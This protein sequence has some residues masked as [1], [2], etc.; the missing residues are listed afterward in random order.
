M[1]QFENQSE[2]GQPEHDGPDHVASGSDEWLIQRARARGE[3][4][5]R[6]VPAITGLDIRQRNV[7]DHHRG[8]D[9]RRAAAT[10]AAAQDLPKRLLELERGAH[11][12]EGIEAAVAVAEPE[13]EGVQLLRDAQPP[14]EQALQQVDGEE[15]DPEAAEEGDDDGHANGGLCLAVLTS[16][17][18][19]RAASLRLGAVNDVL[20]PEQ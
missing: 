2:Q 17:T 20:D 6:A 8:T 7:A 1:N 4:V 13:E 11:V 3:A 15:A 12:D 19:T 5:E 9:G 18:L 14:S 16:M 10:A